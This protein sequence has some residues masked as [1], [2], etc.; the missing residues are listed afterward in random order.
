[1]SQAEKPRTTRANGID[2]KV[3]PR[4]GSQDARRLAA[5]LDRGDGR[6]DRVV[7]NGRPDTLSVWLDAGDEPAHFRPPEGWTVEAVYLDDDT[8]GVC[9]RVEREDD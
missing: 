8:G 1:M 9:A 2:V 4:H 7:A 6:V 3:Y 5:R